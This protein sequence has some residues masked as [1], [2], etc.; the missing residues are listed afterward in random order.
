MHQRSAHSTVAIFLLRFAALIAVT[1]A[2]LLS[3]SVRASREPLAA[4]AS[5]AAAEP[6]ETINARRYPLRYPDSALHR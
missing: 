2:V 4:P 6:A 3:V 5:A 1:L